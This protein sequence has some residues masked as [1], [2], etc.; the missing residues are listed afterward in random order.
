MK[1]ANQSSEHPRGMKLFI[2]S[3]FS[4]F[5][6]M[7]LYIIIYT[8]AFIFIIYI[9]SQIHTDSIHSQLPICVIHYNTM[10]T[11]TKYIFLFSS[12]L[13]NEEV[14]VAHSNPPR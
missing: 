2:I 14:W 5:I 7:H 1:P 4:A 10:F 13:L 3:I 11:I 8:Y 12:V 9:L 6:F